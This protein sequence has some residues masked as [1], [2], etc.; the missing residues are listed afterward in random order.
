MKNE[1]VDAPKM[2]SDKKRTCVSGKSKGDVLLS[3]P[4]NKLYFQSLVVPVNMHAL[5]QQWTSRPGWSQHSLCLSRDGTDDQ[6]SP[7]HDSGL[8]GE[9]GESHAVDSRRGKDPLK[10][11]SAWQAREEGGFAL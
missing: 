1:D 3:L 10:L 11:V 7:C 5:V 6:W 8:L 2:Q 4:Q 9:R